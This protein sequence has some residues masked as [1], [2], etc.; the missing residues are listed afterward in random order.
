MFAYVCPPSFIAY[1]TCIVKARPSFWEGRTK[2][3]AVLQL[4]DDV[5]R[6]GLG[7][8][9]AV[10]ALFRIDVGQAVGDGDGAVL[11]GFLALHAADAADGADLPDSAALVVGSAAHPDDA[12]VGDHLKE[13]VGADLGA[14]AAAGAEVPVYHGQTVLDGQGVKLAGF[15]TV[16][17]T[18]AAIGAAAPALNFEIALAS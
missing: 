5:D 18:Q 17:V 6:A 7:A 13:V 15:H 1:Q 8:G 4:V 11:A 16:A 2:R 3:I 12:A 10:G 9:A 14:G